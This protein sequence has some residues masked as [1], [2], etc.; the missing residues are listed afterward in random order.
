MKF[1]W[2]RDPDRGD[3]YKWTDKISDFRP[4]SRCISETVQY[5]DKDDM[6]D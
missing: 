1:Q 4:I 2:S 5:R 6:E 3:K